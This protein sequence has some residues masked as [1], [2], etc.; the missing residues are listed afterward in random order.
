VVGGLEYFVEL[1]I[2]ILECSKPF[3]DQHTKWIQ[4]GDEWLMLSMIEGTISKQPAK[5]RH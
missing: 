5:Q 3:T 4:I 1:S 2:L